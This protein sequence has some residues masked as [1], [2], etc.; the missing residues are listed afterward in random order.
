LSGEYFRISKSSFF[1]ISAAGVQ[2]VLIENSTKDMVQTSQTGSRAPDAR[3]QSL[4]W[5]M[6]TD[7]DGGDM[8]RVIFGVFIAVGETGPI[9][10]F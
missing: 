2:I 7:E 5:S 6:K 10:I 3:W 1:K 4:Q 8:F 9:F